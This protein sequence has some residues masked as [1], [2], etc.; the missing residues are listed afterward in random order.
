MKIKRVFHHYLLCEEYSS[1]MWKVIDINERQMII[2][3]SAKLMIDSAAFETAC[4]RTVDEWP[5]SCEAALTASSMNHQAW[6]GHAACALNHGASEDL[7]R[8][9]WRMLTEAQQDDANAAA[10]RAI[11]YWKEKYVLNLKN[12]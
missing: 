10:D 12:K 9:G 1:N 2:D 5:Y 4:K 8:L 3:K 6:I 11:A 7:T